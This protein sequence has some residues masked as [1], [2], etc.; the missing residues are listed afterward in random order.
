MHISD[1]VS[2][3]S[4]T[5]YHGMTWT[6]HSFHGTG[7]AKRRILFNESSTRDPLSRRTT[8]GRQRILF[9][10]PPLAGRESFLLDLAVTTR[11]PWQAKNLI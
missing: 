3:D 5:L 2:D 11:S 1:R 10:E 6:D 4:R 9:N 7:E 8:P